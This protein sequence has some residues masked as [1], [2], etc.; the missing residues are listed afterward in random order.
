MMNRLSTWGPVEAPLG[1]V[2]E[3]VVDV[4]EAEQLGHLGVG[5]LL[6]EVGHQVP[7]LADG[8]DR[9]PG[10]PVEVGVLGGR[11]VLGQLPDEADVAA[12]PG[13]LQRPVAQ[14]GDV[15]GLQ[16]GTVVVGGGGGHR[17]DS[18]GGTLAWMTGWSTVARSGWPCS[19]RS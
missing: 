18:S 9:V 6:A 14:G 13:E 3:Q 12:L 17:V 7:D 4:A 1:G 19:A 10:G 2:V 11:Q 15:L 5:G 8:V 16:E